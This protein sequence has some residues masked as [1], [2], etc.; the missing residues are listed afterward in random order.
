MPLPI[1][2]IAMALAQIAPSLMKFFG[3]GD[4]SVLVAE[5]A[6]GIAQTITGTATPEEALAVLQ[7]DQAKQH[8]YRM[9]VMQNEADLERAYLADVQ[10]ARARDTSLREAGYRNIRASVMLAS[11][12]I[13]VLVILAVA[14]WVSPLEEYVKG[15]LTLILGRCLGYV[16]A[17]FNFEFGTTR[18]SGKKDET[19]ST[20]SGR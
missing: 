9:A 15:I 14:V 8:E 12:G 4:A 7:A 13:L 2:P 10:S 3:A 1:I 6:V 18:S 19:I 11:A 5:K 17:G 16:D 20:L